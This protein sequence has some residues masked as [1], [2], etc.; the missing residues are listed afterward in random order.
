MQLIKEGTYY[1]VITVKCKSPGECMLDY[2]TKQTSL[3]AL[4][5]I[6]FPLI[7]LHIMIICIARLL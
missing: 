2:F 3:T 1:F 7:C 5:E 4:L 6:A